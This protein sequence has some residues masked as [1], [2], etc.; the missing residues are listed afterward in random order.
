MSFSPLL[1]Y[2][3]Y[4]AVLAPLAFFSIYVACENRARKGDWRSTAT[5]DTFWLGLFVGSASSVSLGAVLGA[6]AF[7]MLRT[8]EPNN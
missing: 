2:Q 3:A 1:L 6:V 5:K 8:L 4:G 7:V